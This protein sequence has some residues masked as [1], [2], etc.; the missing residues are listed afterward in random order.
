MLT[1]EQ[2]NRYRQDTPGTQHH[3]H[4]NNAGASLMPSPVLA[5]VSKHLETEYLH[6]GYEAAAMNQQKIAAFYPAVA[7]LFHCEAHQIA[8]TTNATDA[9][10]RALSSIP[11]VKGD[12]IL[13]TFDD[14]VSNQLAFLQLK[15]RFGV[16]L[17]YADQLPE[18]GVD[19]QSVWS[20][21]KIH[22]PKLVAVTHMPTNSGLIQDVE[23]VGK[24]CR[25]EDILYLVDG[26]QTAGQLPIDLE[27]LGCDFFSATFRKFLRGPR[28]TGFLYVSERVLQ[29]GL[30]PLFIDLHS[31]YWKTDHGY[32]LASGA[33]RYELWERPYAMMVGAREAAD[34]AYRVGLSNIAN[35]TAHLASRLREGL[36]AIESISVLDHGPSLGAIVTF[37]AEGMEAKYLHSALLEKKVNS[38][39]VFLESARFDFSRKGI[40]WALRL[41]PHYYNHEHEI[42]Q[43]IGIVSD[44]VK[45]RK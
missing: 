28:G 39:L 20:K 15:K 43:V 37:H 30:H 3:I 25:S 22:R 18:G 29:L 32:E 13:T 36:Q 40:D 42:E 17:E 21:I 1:P 9:F 35:R 7:R 44:I 12:R 11:F 23:T 16:Q 19:A 4:L 34:Y 33:R 24:I 26:C 2:I 31:A 41:S 38:S 8:Y 6:G 27:G 5:A 14:Y 45:P 10:S